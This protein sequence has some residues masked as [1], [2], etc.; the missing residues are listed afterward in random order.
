MATSNIEK[1]AFGQAGATIALPATGAVTGDFCA[2]SFIND[3]TLSSL[4]W[5]ELNP[6]GDNGT[7]VAFP[8]GFVLYG[9]ITGFTLLT[10]SVV[11]YKQV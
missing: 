10:G 2:L 3:S 11:A 7:S 6:D 9:Q 4:T 8:A 5:K 1:Q